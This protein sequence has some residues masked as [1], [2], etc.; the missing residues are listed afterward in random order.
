M[1]LHVA[2]LAQARAFYVGVIGFELMQT[3]GGSA[4]FVS[5]GGYHHHLGYNI[6]AGR[7]APPPNPDMAGLRSFEVLLPDQ[8]ALDAVLARLAGAG[9]ETETTDGGHLVPDPSRNVVVLRV[10]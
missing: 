7:G 3:F 5:A 9:L 8:L 4:E 1:H 2:N 6:W 10:E